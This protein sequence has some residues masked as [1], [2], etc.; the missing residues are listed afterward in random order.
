MT[1]YALFI[2]GNPIAY[3]VY[4]SEEIHKVNIKQYVNKDQN[5]VL[6][7]FKNRFNLHYDSI[8]NKWIRNKKE[9]VNSNLPYKQETKKVS[10][11]SNKQFKDK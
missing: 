6:T 3:T 1:K 11:K 8:I 5:W 9:P 10:M 4:G 2:D 7:L